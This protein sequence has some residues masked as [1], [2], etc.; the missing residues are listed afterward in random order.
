MLKRIT[1]VFLC[2]L[3]TN[4][5]GC[6]SVA[7]SSTLRNRNFDY[8]RVNVE[9]LNQPIKTPPGLATP[10]FNPRF[11]IPAGQNAYLPSAIGELTPPGFSQV[12]EIPPV[13]VQ[14]AI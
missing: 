12:Y 7:N 8:A 3:C 5:V 4:L 10:A 1:L 13:K 2:I 11:I 6:S 9:N 14:P